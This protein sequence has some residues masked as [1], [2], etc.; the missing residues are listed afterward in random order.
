MNFTGRIVA[1]VMFA[2]GVAVSS[3]VDETNAYERA[4][5]LV[6]QLAETRGP[7]EF[8]I[9]ERDALIASGPQATE[10]L[11]QILKEAPSDKRTTTLFLLNE[12]VGDKSDAINF[13]ESLLAQDPH[14]WSGQKWLR[15]ALLVLSTSSPEKARQACLRILDADERRVDQL[16]ALTMLKRFGVPTDILRLERLIEERRGKTLLEG[17][18]VDGVSSTALETIQAIR[19][20]A[21]VSANAAPKPLINHDNSSEQKELTSDTSSMGGMFSA[22]RAWWIVS[23]VMLL[24]FAIIWIRHR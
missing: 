4:K 13:I 8:L 7:D 16:V 24:I 22:Q 15:G 6:D 19:E 14:E 21:A 23:I 17:Q 10:I 12:T 11:T 9:R 5:T 3:A 1:L 2:A 18:R 20:R